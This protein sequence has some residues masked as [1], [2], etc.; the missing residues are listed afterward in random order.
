MIP[1]AAGAAAAGRPAASSL[2]FLRSLLGEAGSFVPYFLAASAVCDAASAAAA[3]GT[4][5]PGA[6]GT[7]Y[8][9]PCLAPALVLLLVAA[10]AA[11]AGAVVQSSAVVSTGVL[12]TG[13]TFPSDSCSLAVPED[14]SHPWPAGVEAAGVV[15]AGACWASGLQLALDSCSAWLGL[16]APLAAL[17]WP[18]AAA[19]ALLGA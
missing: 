8:G 3:G 2:L 14:S 16:G 19:E 4:R 17:A 12:G 11:A 10:A 13:E 9:W 15:I 7:G 1:S 18:A 6:A 5:L